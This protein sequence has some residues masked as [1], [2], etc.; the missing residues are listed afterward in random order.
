MTHTN[1]RSLR[2]SALRLWRVFPWDPAASPGEPFSPS[3]IPPRQVSGRFD[4]GGDPLVLN[5]AESPAHAI[6]EHIQSGRARQLGPDDLMEN[7][8][9]LAMVEVTICPPASGIVADLC[10]PRELSRFGCR[11]DQ[12][13]SRKLLW[14]QSLSQRL[15]RAGLFGFRVWSALTGDWHSTIL[16]MDRVSTDATVNYGSPMWATLDHPAVRYAAWLLDIA[17]ESSADGPRY[18]RKTAAIGR[19]ARASCS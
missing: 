17:V 18:A 9:P 13:M 1:Y 11:P 7:G 16:F 4:L 5:L 10:K 8:R 2:G 14:T 3:Y 15:H 19:K 12:L 6:G